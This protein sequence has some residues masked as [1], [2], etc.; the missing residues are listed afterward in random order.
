MFGALELGLCFGHENRGTDVRYAVSNRTL[1]P[2]P[3]HTYC[4]QG[5][6]GEKADFLARTSNYS[7]R[8]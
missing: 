2:A 6:I 8:H 4:G 5:K 3:P 1:Q 7:P